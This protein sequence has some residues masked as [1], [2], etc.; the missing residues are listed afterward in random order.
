ME[1]LLQV[2]PVIAAIAGF[3]LATAGLMVGLFRWLRAE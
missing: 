2:W 3:F 1:A